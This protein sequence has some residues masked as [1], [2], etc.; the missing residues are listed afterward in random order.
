MRACI[1]GLEVRAG[2]LHTV[3]KRPRPHDKQNHNGGET[4]VAMIWLAFYLLALGVA[5]T[6]PILSSAIEFA[7]R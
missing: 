4:A 2:R 3:R 1:D 5:V 7:A 6:S